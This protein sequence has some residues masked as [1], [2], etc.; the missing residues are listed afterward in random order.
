MEKSNSKQFAYSPIVLITIGSCVDTVCN[1]N[2]HKLV[3]FVI[4]AIW[5]QTGICRDEDKI[6]KGNV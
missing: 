4:V 3:C 6:M 5:V 1:F 2:M